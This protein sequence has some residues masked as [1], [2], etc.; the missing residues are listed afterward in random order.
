MEMVA[1]DLKKY[2]YSMKLSLYTARVAKRI[3]SS[4]HSESFKSLQPPS[5]ESAAFHVVT[6]DS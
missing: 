3:D 2:L 4:L 6:C 5:D 1:S